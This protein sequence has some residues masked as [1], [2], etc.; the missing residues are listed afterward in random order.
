MSTETPAALA[1]VAPLPIGAIP[2]PLE[3][4]GTAGPAVAPTA[5]L[6]GHVGGAEPGVDDGREHHADPR[7][8][9]LE[10]AQAAIIGAFLLAGSA[11][12]A[13]IVSIAAPRHGAAIAGVQLVLVAL[14]DGLMLWWPGH[15]HPFNR[16]RLDGERLRIFRGALFRTEIDVPRSRVQHTDV[17]QGPLQRRLG[18]ATL[19]VH[20]AGAVASTVE[21][22]GLTLETARAI[23]DRLVTEPAAPQDAERA[24]RP[25]PSPDGTDDTR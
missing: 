6:P 5:D 23:R 11:G 10:R 19:V 16:F 13:A 18:L 7:N 17:T 3:P 2:P 9:T 20:T 14:L 8:V 12:A 25:E 22:H 1:P 21:L 4:G 15:V 24:G